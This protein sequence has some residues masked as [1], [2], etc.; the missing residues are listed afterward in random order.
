MHALHTLGVLVC[1][2]GWCQSKLMQWLNEREILGCW[3]TCTAC[4]VV[5]KMEVVVLVLSRSPNTALIYATGSWFQKQHVR[6][7]RVN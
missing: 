6:G 3:P 1:A 5:C 2:E 7:A 4:S